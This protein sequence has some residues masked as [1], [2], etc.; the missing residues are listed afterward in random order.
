MTG[1]SFLDVAAQTDR[2]RI[3]DANGINMCVELV[4]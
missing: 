2:R 4:L 3:K 1:W